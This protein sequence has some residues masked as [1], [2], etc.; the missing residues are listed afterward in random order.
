MAPVSSGSAPQLPRP[1]TA[2]SLC[3]SESV[4]YT[5]PEALSARPSTLPL[6]ALA[7]STPGRGPSGAIA[8]ALAPP[9]AGSALRGQA[10]P[11]PRMV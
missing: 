9:P 7:L 11:L 10:V 6:M 5:T 8:V 4:K 3:C 2:R 1:Y